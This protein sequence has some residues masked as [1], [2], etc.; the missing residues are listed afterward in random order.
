MDI[1]AKVPEQSLFGW[2]DAVVFYEKTARKRVFKEGEEELPELLLADAGKADSM[3]EQADRALQT[4]ATQM[5]Q[6]AVFMDRQ[7]RALVGLFDMTV[8]AVR[9]WNEI[10]AA[11][12][13]ENQGA[14]LH[15]EETYALAGRLERWFMAF[16]AQW[17]SIGREGDLCHI[18]KII[19]WYADRLRCK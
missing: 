15:P 1:L 3:V 13:H 11:V 14:A 9:L 2:R 12:A 5:K 7:A 10:G 18:A 6:N 19:F 16:K 17:R 8:E 4:L